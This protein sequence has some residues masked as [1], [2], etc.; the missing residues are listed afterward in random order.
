MKFFLNRGGWV[1]ASG[2]PNKFNMIFSIGSRNNDLKYNLLHHNN[3]LLCI[4]TWDI[5]NSPL[6]NV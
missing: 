6:E 4:N 3:T 5:C 1:V 2:S